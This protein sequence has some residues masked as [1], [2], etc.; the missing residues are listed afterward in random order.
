MAIEIDLNVE[1]VRDDIVKEAARQLLSRTTF[2]EDGGEVSLPSDLSKR[3]LRH[4]DEA[5]RTV[6]AEV[7]E[8]IVRE[9][10]ESK[11]P[12]YDRYGY[13]EKGEGKTLAEKI[14]DEVR[15]R[16]TGS[17]HG[18][19]SRGMIDGLIAEHVTRALSGEL[20]KTIE[21]A[22]GEVLVAVREEGV[23]AIEEA[24]RR[25]ASRV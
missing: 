24:L 23:K 4:V 18:S 17:R 19:T 20:R 8:P 3:L 13:A 16:L 12:T 21:D 15:A 14:G 5:L 11:L 22:K 1:E 7:A 6:T 9:A 2:D 10:L 25:S